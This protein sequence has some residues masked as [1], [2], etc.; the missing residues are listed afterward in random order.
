MLE[1]AL[2][3]VCNANHGDLDL[4][5]H[6][7]LWAYRITCKRL[8][9]KTPFK[10]VYSQEVMML[11]AYIVPSLRIAPTLGIS[12]EGDIE[13][14]LTQLLQFEEDR[15]IVGFHQQVEKD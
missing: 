13:E 7:I 15:F 3:K 4:K 2:T 1:H 9:G 10:I 6:V 5:V 12:D 11:M 8:I 14:R